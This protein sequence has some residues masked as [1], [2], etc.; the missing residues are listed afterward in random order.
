MSGASCGHILPWAWYQSQLHG[1]SCH[2]KRIPCFAPTA[3]STRTPSGITSRPMPSPGMTAIWCSFMKE[4]LSGI[5]SPDAFRV[6]RDLHRV[7]LGRAVGR[8]RDRSARAPG[9]G[10]PWHEVIPAVCVA[11]SVAPKLPGEDW[12]GCGNG[13]AVY[14]DLGLTRLLPEVHPTAVAV[15]RLAGPRLQAGEG[16]DAAL[17]APIYVREKV[18]F[19]KQELENR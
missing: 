12:V 6:D 1:N 17:A 10:A 11:P 14:G 18:A 4:I 2:L 13:F 15:A 19:T 8:W 16:V 5:E 9:R 7:V 3:S